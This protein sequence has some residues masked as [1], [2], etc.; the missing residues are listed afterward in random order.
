[1]KKYKDLIGVGMVIVLF[2]LIILLAIFPER[3]I[4][5]ILLGSIGGPLFLLSIFMYIKYVIPIMKEMRK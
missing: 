2:I 1:M 3:E 5:G 4:Q